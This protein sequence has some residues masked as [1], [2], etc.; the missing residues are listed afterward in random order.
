MWTRGMIITVTLA[1]V[2]LPCHKQL[3]YGRRTAENLDLFSLTF[4]AHYCGF[5][6]FD[7]VRTLN[8]AYDY[9]KQSLL[10]QMKIPSVHDTIWVPKRLL[11]RSILHKSSSIKGQKWAE[12]ICS[13]IS[14]L[15]EEKTAKRKRHYGNVKELFEDS[16]DS[17]NSSDVEAEMESTN[18]NEVEAEMESTNSNEGLHMD[19]EPV[20]KGKKRKPLGIESFV[21][22]VNISAEDFSSEVVLTSEEVI[23]NQKKFLCKQAEHY[24]SCL[25]AEH[26]ELQIP[27]LKTI[28][29]E[30]QIKF[31]EMEKHKE[32]KEVEKGR[33]RTSLLSKMSTKV[34]AAEKKL[35][36]HMELYERELKRRKISGAERV[37]QMKK[38]VHQI[39]NHGS[40]C[41]EEKEKEYRKKKINK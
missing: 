18:S 14:V 22:K 10:D 27:K 34:N 39:R 6:A 26:A 2:E 25:K 15:D 38:V 11:I 12:D 16:E 17:L 23:E 8:L 29:N 40:Q 24:E 19:W 28:A 30:L 35:K 32:N 41:D 13:L 5:R 1:G 37:E 36:N 31:N 20:R 9:T 3:L 4:A 33:G 7:I 21:D